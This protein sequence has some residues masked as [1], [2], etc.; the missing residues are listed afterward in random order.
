[1]GVAGENPHPMHTMAYFIHT[2]LLPSR[3]PVAVREAMPYRIV[4]YGDPPTGPTFV[5]PLDDASDYID[6]PPVP[7]LSTLDLRGPPPTGM[8]SNPALVA[9]LFASLPDHRSHTPP[10]AAT[11]PDPDPY[12]EIREEAKSLPP[13]PPSPP[14][15]ADL[16]KLLADSRR[17]VDS[18]M[19]SFEDEDQARGVASSLNETKEDATVPPP[20]ALFFDEE[21]PDGQTV[22]TLVNLPPPPA[23]RCVNGE[24]LDARIA[25]LTLDVRFP[26]SVA[27]TCEACGQSA[28]TKCFRDETDS[29]VCSACNA[30]MDDYYAHQY[31]PRNT[32][33]VDCPSC[34]HPNSSDDWVHAVANGRP[35]WLCKECN[36]ALDLPAELV[37]PP[38]D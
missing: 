34:G 3:I 38:H 31:S 26:P 22:R 28:D 8:G 9:R 7:Y 12:E 36:H 13:A 33:V 32:G 11:A 6:R 16:D 27:W 35:V 15:A 24:R 21:R 4:S 2:Y 20:T 14:A 23:A 18:L 25:R 1:M 37:V 30:A 10:P 29:W 5:L 19:Q 17:L